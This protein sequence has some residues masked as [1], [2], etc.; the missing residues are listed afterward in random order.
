MGLSQTAAVE[1]VVDDVRVHCCTS[2]LGKLARIQLNETVYERR[3]LSEKLHPC[4]SS[5][6]YLFFLGVS[7]SL[8]LLASA[9]LSFARAGNA[10][11]SWCMRLRTHTWEERS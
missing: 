8:L 6:I 5:I 11:A 10:F 7:L 2:V 9:C 3:A 4:G 1:A